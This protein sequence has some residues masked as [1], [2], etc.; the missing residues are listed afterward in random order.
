VD[1]VIPPRRVVAL[2]VGLVLVL[3]GC[4][5]AKPILSAPAST[6]VTAAPPTTLDI[7]AG[8]STVV[9]DPVYPDYGNPALD[10][11][12]YQLQLA[13]SP[14]QRTLTG[15][16]VLTIRATKAV[17]Q[18]TLDFSKAYTVDGVAVSG[19]ATAHSFDGDDIVVPARLEADARTVLEVRYHGRP[20]PVDMPSQRGD[21]DEGLGLRAATG[22]EAW[23][24]QEPYGASTW[25]PANDTPSDEAVYDTFVTVPTGWTA[26]AHGQ[27]LGIDR[28]SDRDTYRWQARDPVAAYLA[29]LA[30]GRYT[31]LTDVGPNN[32]PITYWVRTGKDEAYE[33]ALRRTPELLAWLA[34]RFGPYPFPSAGVVIVDSE[35]AM[36]TQQMVTYGADLGA[37]SD[38]LEYA[39]E[40]LLHEFAHQWFGNAVTPTDWT[41]LWLNE[42]FAMYAEMLW[43]IDQGLGTDAAWV[44]F[45]RS[46]DARSRAEAGPPGQ[47]DPDRFAEENVYVGP[48]LML[49]E[50]RL[51]VGDE[52]FYAFARDWV[53]TQRNKPVERATF[54]RF[55]NQ[56][57]GRDFT[58]LVNAWLDSPTT[59]PS[60]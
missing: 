60:T 12:A 38:D 23:T 8:L 55:L 20:R 35:S 46:T 15:T 14:E 7:S 53:Q 29:T 4:T 50:I 37:G 39:A 49:R 24:M 47:P 59:P 41:G 21:F 5:P 11:L 30:L 10:V 51:A 31:Q 34:A 40:I 33:P 56:H 17:D 9:K 44:S 52:A 45:A 25:Y 36:E 26:V 19:A 58:N 2:L 6:P 48:A 54:V 13:W 43:T 28:G 57:T 27:L 16:A 18:L 22:G 3:G 42:G 32:L 1:A